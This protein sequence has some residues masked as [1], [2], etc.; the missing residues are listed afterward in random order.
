MAESYPKRANHYAHAF[1]RK[2]TKT[3]VANT[4]GP[5]VCWLL[6][7]VAHQEDAKRYTG[8]VTY[9]ND[10][11]MAVAGLGSVDRLNRIRS[12]AVKAG[13]LHY[14]PGGKGRVGVYW[15]Q[16]PDWAE[17]LSDGTSDESAPSGYGSQNATTNTEPNPKETREKPETNAGE[18]ED[19]RGTSY[20]NPSPNPSP[21][22]GAAGVAAEVVSA[23]NGLKGVSRCESLSESRRDKLNTR[24]REPWWRG[25]WL[26]AIAR[27]PGARW[28]HENDQGWKA[29]IDWFLRPNTAAKLLEGSYDRLTRS[30][31]HR[32]IAGLEY[33][34]EAAESFRDADPGDAGEG[35]GIPPGR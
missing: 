19:N 11:L 21:A 18:A 34:G 22:A 27:I 30:N 15:V 16:I 7:V 28:L 2:L 9:W 23:W 6:T 17:K 20:P 31:G 1:C 25:N 32:R 33:E 4:L 10:Q 26:N 35:E 8:P 3:A 24:L 29:D 12:A 13:W 5:E 14:E